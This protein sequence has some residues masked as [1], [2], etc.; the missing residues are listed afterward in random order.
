MHNARCEQKK[1]NKSR[2]N[3]IQCFYFN[4]RDNKIEKRFKKRKIE[5]QNHSNAP[6]STFIAVVLAFEWDYC[7]MYWYQIGREINCKTF[8]AQPVSKL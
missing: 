8:L 3:Q 6:C 5:E 4:G 7:S 2:H 1:A